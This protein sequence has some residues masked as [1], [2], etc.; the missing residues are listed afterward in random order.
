MELGSVNAKFF[1]N[2][3]YYPIILDPALTQTDEDFIE[4][5]EN[6]ITVYKVVHLTLISKAR[7]ATLVPKIEARKLPCTVFSDDLFW[8]IKNELT[9]RNIPIDQATVNTYLY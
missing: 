6:L 1:Y 8:P 3:D 7:L 2:V 4:A 9:G 5:I